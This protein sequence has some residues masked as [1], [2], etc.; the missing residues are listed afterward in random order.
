MY[1]LKAAVLSQNFCVNGSISESIYSH[2]NK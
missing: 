2:N 1:S